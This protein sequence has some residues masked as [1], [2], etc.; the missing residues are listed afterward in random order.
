MSREGPRSCDYAAGRPFGDERPGHARSRAWSLR[1][2]PAAFRYGEAEA[3]RFQPL[4]PGS[5][6]NGFLLRG[7]A[8]L[9]SLAAA[10]ELPGAQ[11]ISAERTFVGANPSIYS[12]VRVTT[13]R[14]IYR[15]SV[16]D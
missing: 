4:E 12:F 3:V 14:N 6:W 7:S 2:T 5:E 8:G 9:P 13:H 1:D 10:G 15:I 11:A 16:P